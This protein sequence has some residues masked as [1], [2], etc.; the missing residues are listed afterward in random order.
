MD[1]LPEPFA[2]S[3][4]EACRMSTLGKTRLYQLIAEGRLEARKIGKRTLI[5]SLMAHL[6]K[7]RGLIPR[8]A[9][10]CHVASHT[11]GP[12]S[13]EALQLAMNWADYLES[14]AR[15][16]YGAL[17][18]DSASAA[19]SIWRRIVRAELPEPFTAR[20]IQRKGWGGLANKERVEAGL[21][22]LCEAE[23]LATCQTQTG[24]TGGRP[25]ILYRPNPNALAQAGRA[26][27][28]RGA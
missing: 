17:S 1:I 5:P 11:P 15:R 28:K 14:H 3:V 21:K 13:V 2:Y 19:R 16:A 24:P 22:A 12:V 10:L 27:M 23:W 25:S 20:D 26:T 8:L 6:S 4:N 7:Y 18:L 9:L